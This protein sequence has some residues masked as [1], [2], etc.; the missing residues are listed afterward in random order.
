MD[1]GSVQQAIEAIARNARAQRQIIDDILDVSR[2]I[3]GSFALE[4]LPWIFLW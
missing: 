1:A 2:I 4:W 3:T